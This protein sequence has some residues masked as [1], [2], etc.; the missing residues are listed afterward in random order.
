MSR[1][2]RRSREAALQALYAMDFAKVDRHEMTARLGAVADHDVFEQDEFSARLLQLVEQHGPDIEQ[3]IE[4]ALKGW[5]RERLGAPDR[6]MLRLGAAEILYCDDIPARVTINEY[7]E[8]AKA[9]GDDESPGFVNAILD[10][11]H[12]DHEQAARST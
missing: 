11:V 3:A 8:L 6:A 9:Y 1:R 4:R 10:R 7:I 5:T 2:R 12:K